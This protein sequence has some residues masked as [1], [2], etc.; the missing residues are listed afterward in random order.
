VFY[1]FW[2]V[3]MAFLNLC[4]L[5]FLLVL[6]RPYL[7]SFYAQLWCCPSIAVPDWFS[8]IPSCNAA[9]SFVSSLYT[10]PFIK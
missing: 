6:S 4:L 2:F 8:L 3:A 9:S 7:N 10:C 5:L 1:M